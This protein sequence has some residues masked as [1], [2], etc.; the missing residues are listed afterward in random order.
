[1]KQNC[2]HC[3]YYIPISCCH[4]VG[5]CQRNAPFSAGK[6]RGEI[7]DGKEFSNFFGI[8]RDWPQVGKV[9]FC[10]EWFPNI[11]MSQN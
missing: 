6:L 5:T 1:M 10:G 9:E 2:E 11:E 8:N 3:K 7:D 4:D